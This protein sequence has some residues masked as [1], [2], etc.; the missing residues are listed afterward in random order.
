VKGYCEYRVFST[1]LITIAASVE[2]YRCPS[3]QQ[4]RGLYRCRIETIFIWRIISHQFSW[5]L[6]AMFSLAPRWKL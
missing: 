4:I 5:D 6:S 2:P 1:P 3:R